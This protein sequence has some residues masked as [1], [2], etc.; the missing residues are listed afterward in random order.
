MPKVSRIISEYF[1]NNNPSSAIGES[2]RPWGKEPPFMAIIRE[3]YKLEYG[4]LWGVFSDPRSL[5]SRGIGKSVLALRMLYWAYGSWD[6]AKNYIFYTPQEFV[7]RF[8]ELYDKGRRVPLVVWDDAGEWLF[9]ARFREKFAITV[10]EY[11]EVI[12]TVVANLLFTATSINK[13]LKG[14]RESIKYVILIKSEGTWGSGDK[15]VKVSKATLYLNSEDL[16]AWSPNRKRPEPLMEYTFYVLLPDHVYQWY[17]EYRRKYVGLALEKTRRELEALAKEAMEELTEIV[18]SADKKHVD[19]SKDESE[20]EEE[21]EMDLEEFK[22]RF[23][24]S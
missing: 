12:R 23:G 13:L 8:K 11:L 21:V 2:N 5:F 4:S 24:Y 7:D 3:N 20:E 6:E 9:R 1:N 16:W 18:R 15:R 22:T 10:I 19:E 14:V 17:N